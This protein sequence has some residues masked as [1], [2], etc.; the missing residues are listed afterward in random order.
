MRGF[1]SR[2]LSPQLVVLQPGSTTSTYAVPV[3]GNGLFELSLEARYGLTA[4]LVLAA[5]VDT[6]FVTAQH[7][8]FTRLRYFSDNL[9]VAVGGGARYLTPVGPIRLD[10]GYRLDVGPPLQVGLSPGT[11]PPAPG[12]CFGLGGK[13]AGAGAPEGRC[14]IHISIGEAF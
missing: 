14:V 1:N 2:R 11:S 4:S 3:G 10:F 13:R 6:G 7:V 8:D 5:F 9:L 12:R